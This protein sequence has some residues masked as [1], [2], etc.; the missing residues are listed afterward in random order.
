MNSRLL[1]L[2]RELRDRIWDFAFEGTE[3]HLRHRKDGFAFEGRD[4]HPQQSKHVITISYPI[5]NQ[6]PDATD[7]ALYAHA[8][9]PL[10][11]LTTPQILA[12]GLEQ[13]SRRGIC[14]RI[15]KEDSLPKDFPVETIYDREVLLFN[16]IRTL[17]LNL[18]LVALESEFSKDIDGPVIRTRIVP[19]PGRE[20]EPVI[21]TLGKAQVADFL[22]H[23]TTLYLRF[24]VERLEDFAPP[25]LITVSAAFL[26]AL[27]TDYTHI[28]ISI[29]R[30][31][32][33]HSRPRRPPLSPTTV[34]PAIPNVA[35][36]S[37]TWC[38]MQRALCQLGGHLSR[39]LGPMRA[40]RPD[41]RWPSVEY[42][43]SGCWHVS[44]HTMHPCDDFEPSELS[45]RETW[46]TIVDYMDD[47]TGEWT[48]E[49]EEREGKDQNGEVIALQ[50]TGLRSFRTPGV[51][52]E[53]PS[54]LFL[55]DEK[56]REGERSWHCAETGDLVWVESKERGT[57]GYI[58]TDG[59]GANQKYVFEGPAQPVYQPPIPRMYTCNIGGFPR[60][61]S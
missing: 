52:E 51:K 48:V 59:E 9:Q 25:K 10:W 26:T 12:E 1:S 56:I 13:F 55:R 28:F 35:S 60:P 11:L 57:T 15:T 29:P 5:S 19:G 34:T 43:I 39:H 38:R 47:D 3:I 8:H 22:P 40:R 44:E 36:L 7:R 49:I 45:K 30:P 61:T 4:I 33:A 27:G 23:A 16:R 53:Q 18:R 21:P 20:D 42:H 31:H 32:F 14:T 6:H 50:K 41:D 54:R 58:G 2:P 24:V 37:V 17:S 46:F